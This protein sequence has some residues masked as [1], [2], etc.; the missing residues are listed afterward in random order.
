M[1][2]AGWAF[3][4]VARLERQLF[5]PDICVYPG[6]AKNSID[7]LTRDGST[8]TAPDGGDD[9]TVTAQTW[10][11]HSSVARITEDRAIPGSDVR[12]SGIR[13]KGRAGWSA[14][15]TS[16]GGDRRPGGHNEE[17]AAL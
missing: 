16:R 14:T 12:I 6:K 4:S 1:R 2:M 9:G 8:V 5:V 11:S 17:T 3:R 7:T 13:I 10:H 15:K